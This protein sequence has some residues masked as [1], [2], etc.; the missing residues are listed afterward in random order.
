MTGA[1]ASATLSLVPGLYSNNGI[2]IEAFIPLGLVARQVG[3]VL[4]ILDICD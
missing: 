4:D 2:L 3:L 1:R